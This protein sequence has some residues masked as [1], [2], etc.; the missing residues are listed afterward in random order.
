[1]DV[2]LFEVRDR[3]T[4]I[5]AFGLATCSRVERE[6]KMLRR[7]GFSFDSDLILFGRIDGGLCHY[8]IY[9]SQNGARTMFEAHKHITENW[10][11]LRSGD[12][13]DVEYILGESPHPKETDLA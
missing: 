2:K 7:S 4:C 3:G 10:N 11:N 1:M 12:I 6:Q 8:D 5:M 13:I 9:E